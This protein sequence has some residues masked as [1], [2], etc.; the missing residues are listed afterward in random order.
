MPKQMQSYAALAEEKYH[1]LIM[2]YSTF[3]Y[4]EVQEPLP[5]PPPR[6]R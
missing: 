6:K 3:R 2:L 5:Q 4:Y 1:L